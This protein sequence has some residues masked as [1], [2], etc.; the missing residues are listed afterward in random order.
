MIRDA[1][2]RE[3]TSDA[4]EEPSRGKDAADEEGRVDAEVGAPSA[5]DVA[6]ADG[7]EDE[8]SKGEDECK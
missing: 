8:R 4:R 3:L 6:Q 2:A 5:L 1:P 7:G